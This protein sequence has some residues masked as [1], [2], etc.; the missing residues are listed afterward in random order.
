M[1]LGERNADGTARA[2]IVADGRREPLPYLAFFS[3]HGLDCGVL[4]AGSMDLARS[5]LADYFGRIPEAWL[6]S[7]FLYGVIHRLDPRAPWTISSTEI[8]AW[9]TVVEVQGRLEGP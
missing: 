2:V 7:A 3:R 8:A 1:Y 5:I 9:L 4:S 6:Y